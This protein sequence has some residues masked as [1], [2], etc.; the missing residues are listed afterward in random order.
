MFCALKLRLLKESLKLLN[1]D[2]C[3]DVCRGDE[4]VGAM[5]LCCLGCCGRGADA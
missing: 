5:G 2:G 4:N 1:A 3:A